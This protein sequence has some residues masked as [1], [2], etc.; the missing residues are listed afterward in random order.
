MHVVNACIKGNAVH[1]AVLGLD[2][3]TVMHEA[4]P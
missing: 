3:A 2:A 1:L 4:N